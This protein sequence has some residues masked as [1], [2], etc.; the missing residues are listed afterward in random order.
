MH[1]LEAVA[2]LT[3]HDAFLG[4]WSLTKEMP[5]AQR[6]REATEA[7]LHAMPSHP[8]IVSASILAALGGLFGDVHSTGRTAGSTL[9]INVLMTLYWC[10][11]LDPVARRVLYLNDILH[12][13]TIRDVTYA[14]E[15]FRATLPATKGRVN[16]PV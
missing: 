8:S 13:Q 6:Y 10:F 7:V 11:R 5:E 2:E 12:T 9:F 14:I 1:F 15:L 3:R 16:L 4:T